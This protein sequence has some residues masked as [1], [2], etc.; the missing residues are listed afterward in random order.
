MILV[1]QYKYAYWIS[2]GLYAEA[3]AVKSAWRTV[4]VRAS[5]L[6]P[7]W[8]LALSHLAVPMTYDLQRDKNRNLVELNH[9]LQKEETYSSS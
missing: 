7:Y 4:H 1:V 9:E 2:E 6:S 3:R 8:E 5:K